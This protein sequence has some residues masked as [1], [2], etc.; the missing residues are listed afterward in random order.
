MDSTHAMPRPSVCGGEGGGGEGGRGEGG[1]GDGGGGVMP[2]DLPRRMF[3][4]P[5]KK[6]PPL[7]KNLV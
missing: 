6:N 1:G 2:L 4:I 3:A 7:A 5:K